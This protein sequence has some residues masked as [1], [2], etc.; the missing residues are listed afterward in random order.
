MYAFPAAEAL[1]EAG[2][3]VSVVNPARVAAY[4]KSKLSRNK[5]DKLDAG[6]I[7]D[8][9]LTQNPPLWVP[10]GPEYAELRALVR[11][12]NGLKDIQQA[13]KNRLGSGLRSAAVAKI[14]QDHIAYLDHQIK[15]LLKQIKA[16]VKNHP[17]LKRQKERLVTI[18]GIGE[19][20]AFKLLAEMPE[21]TLFE[22][23]RQL[24]A[25]AGLNPKHRQ[26]GKLKGRTPISKTGNANLRSALYMPAIV[27]KKHNPIVRD[28]CGRLEGD[29][30]PM[31]VIVAA[32]RKLLHIAYGVLKNNQPFDPE[33]EKLL[34]LDLQ[35]AVA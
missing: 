4:A 21:Y 15:S 5:T 30:L 18:P 23:A 33:Y 32:M 22:D 34:V 3:L 24:A 7:A 19:L 26:S 6:L 16:H 28:F 10:P 2:C 8:F 20:T 29:K 13:E 9:C 11:L 31:E 14:L 27:A 1:L 17:N 35:E 25:F 12:L